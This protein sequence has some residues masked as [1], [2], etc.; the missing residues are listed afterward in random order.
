MGLFSFVCCIVLLKKITDERDVLI[1]VLVVMQRFRPRVSSPVKKRRYQM[2][3]IPVLLCLFIFAT[4][5]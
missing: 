1:A 5:I 3:K 4:N 2:L